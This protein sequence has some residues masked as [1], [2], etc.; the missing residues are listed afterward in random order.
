MHIQPSIQVLSEEAIDQVHKSSLRVLSEIGIRVDSENA[1]KIFQASK[2]KQLGITISDHIAR[3]SSEAVNW[4]IDQV[5]STI[6][7]YNRCGEHAFRLG[8]GQARFGIGVTNLFYQEPENHAIL[9]FS[10][11][12]LRSTLSLGNSLQSY[13]VISTVG[14]LHDVDVSKADLV[15]TLEML[16]GTTKP[17]IILISDEKQ[18]KP[19]LQLI[20]HLLPNTSEKPFVIP[21]FNPVTPLILN[22]STTDNMI[23]SI[24]KG[25]PIIYSNYGMAGVS[26]PITSAGTLA[27]LNA[28]LLA[29]L[30]F[31]QLSNQ[32]LRSS[33]AAFQHSSI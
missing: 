29:G 20:D 28:E 21:Y 23:R 22:R 31:T 26:S 19:V 2:V 18:F 33:S 27:L 1:Q 13:E 5:P 14:I 10:R 32:A 30:I 12:H 6:D 4:A 9:P 11:S 16:A 8:E 24:E 3:F 17:L 15:A 7:I 25:I